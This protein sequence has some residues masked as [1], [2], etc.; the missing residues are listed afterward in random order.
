MRGL[1]RGEK[2]LFLWLVTAHHPK[3]ISQSSSSSIV[4]SRRNVYGQI[5]GSA[6]HQ[7]IAL[8]KEA[9]RPFRSRVIMGQCSQSNVTSFQKAR[10]LLVFLH[11]LPFKNS[12]FID[13]C[14]WH[15]W[16]LQRGA[17]HL[18]TRQLHW[19]ATTGKS[20]LSKLPVW[21]TDSNFEYCT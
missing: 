10:N 1:G 21:V 13:K 2:D 8:L 3:V 15:I 17:L 12:S 7:F 6:K 11:L 16:G 19:R 14:M 20:S 4:L 18:L 9:S 5:H